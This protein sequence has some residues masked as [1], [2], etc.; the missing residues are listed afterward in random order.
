M[1]RYP[2]TS[3]G[4]RRR[5][6]RS[7]LYAILVLLIIAAVIACIYGY[8]S[9]DKNKG[10]SPGSMGTPPPRISLPPEPNLSKPPPGPVAKLNPEV[11]ELIT[12][13]TEHINAKPARIREAREILND[14]LAMPMN[15]QQRTVVKDRLCELANEWLFSRKFFPQNQLCT[16]YQV[17]PGDQLRTIGKQHQVP[18]EI[19]RDINKIG[20][21]ENLQAG[22]RIKVINGPFHARVYRSTFSMD[23]YLQDTFVRSFKVGLGIPGRETPTGLW[24]VEP[25]G[26][27]IRPVW[28]DPDTSKVY[29]PEDPDYPLGSRWI[30]LKG[31]EGDAVGRTGIAFHG[32]KDPNLIGTVG[33]RGCIRLHNGDVILLYNLLE[34]GSSRVE[35]V[36]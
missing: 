9:L 26:K 14:A 5:R 35:V 25:G 17:R 6:I 11:A 8:R 31:L 22:D 30:R 34:P 28:R 29:Y 3:Y 21:P 4:R 2:S 10:T 19:L 7:W 12:Q 1:A 36:D 23:L 18:W 15:T 16:S 32:T 33:S 27:A 24:V 13:A 20:R